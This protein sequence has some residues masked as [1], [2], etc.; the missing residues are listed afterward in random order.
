M[1]F[2]WVAFNR[3]DYHQCQIFFVSCLLQYRSYVRAYFN[4]LWCKLLLYCS[5]QSRAVVDCSTTDW[6]PFIGFNVCVIYAK[7]EW[8]KPGCLSDD[9]MCD[10]E[11]VWKQ[12]QIRDRVTK[13]FLYLIWWIL[14]IHQAWIAQKLRRKRPVVDFIL[15][16]SKLVLHWMQKA[17][18][19]LGRQ[20]CSLL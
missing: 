17:V 20:A 6:N 8:L 19:F 5:T 18:L 4:L 9:Q 2:K 10:W 11:V 15:F 1:F 12:G 7:A 13:V 3:L 14:P 16:F